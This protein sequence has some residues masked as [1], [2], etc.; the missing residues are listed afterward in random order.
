MLAGSVLA[1]IACNN[2]DYLSPDEST[3]AVVAE[4]A[5]APEL[6]AMSV[7]SYRNGIPFGTTAQPTSTF[8]DLYNG[9]LRNIWPKYL[10][11]ELNA[12]RVR[13]G[14]VVLMFAGSERF[15]KDRYGHFDLS[16]WKARVARFRGVNFSSYLKDGTIV[17]H[18]LIDEPQDPANW[19]GRP[20][21]GRTL[22]EM[23]RYSKQLWP[24]MTTIVRAEPAKIRWSGRYQYLDAAWAQ[25]VYR[26][27]DVHTFLRTA[28]SD[29]QR[30]GLGLVVGLN[31]SKGSPSKSRMSPTQILNAG[32]ALLS[33]SYPCAFI[34]WRYEST[35]LSTSGVRAARRNLRNKAQAR[36]IKTCRSS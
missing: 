29:A 18:Y 4:P 24:N 21:T 2:T 9:A 3:P 14:R 6:S 33:S 23:A 16:K 27:G 17:G 22:E 25:Y 12:I 32:S 30:M 8:G 1:C 36:S 34:S 10:L 28:V 13:G 35:Y 31:I 11:H 26:R 15:Y 5:A 7:A 20:I 19:N